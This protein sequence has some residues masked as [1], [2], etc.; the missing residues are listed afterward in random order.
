MSLGVGTKKHGEIT[1]VKPTDIDKRVYVTPIEAKIWFSADQARYIKER[2]WS[3]DQ[4]IVEQEDGSVILEMN[5]SGWWDVK[6]WVLSFGA[7]A[8]VLEPAALR[9]EIMGELKATER[10]YAL[11]SD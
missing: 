8:K 4:K 5:T 3:A 6:K 2:R 10:N 11:K 9:K 1:R 7:E